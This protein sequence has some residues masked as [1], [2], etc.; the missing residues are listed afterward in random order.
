MS[1]QNAL[2]FIQQLRTEEGLKKQ[3]LDINDTPELETIVKIVAGAG[4]YFTV[5]ELQ[6]TQKHN[7]AMR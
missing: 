4:F 7:W 5:E 3:I 2:Q 1:V 6:S